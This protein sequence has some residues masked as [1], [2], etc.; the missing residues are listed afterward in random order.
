M[1][2]LLAAAAVAWLA[3]IG[4]FAYELSRPG[5]SHG[6]TDGHR[7]EVGPRPVPPVR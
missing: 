1:I 4:F 6:L 7:A 2:Y 5:V 3:I